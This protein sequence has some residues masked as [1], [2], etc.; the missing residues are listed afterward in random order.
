MLYDGSTMDEDYQYRCSDVGGVLPSLHRDKNKT[1]DLPGDFSLLVDSSHS[2]LWREVGIAKSIRS[3]SSEFDQSGNLF[4]RNPGGWQLRAHLLQEPHMDWPTI[5]AA[6]VTA[7][8]ASSPAV[9]ALILGGRL[10]HADTAT[11]YQDLADKTIAKYDALLEL[12]DTLR[13]G[14]GMLQD[15]VDKL[16]DENTKKEKFITKLLEYIDY[17][18]EL[19]NKNGIVPERPRP[20]REETL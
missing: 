10:R 12:V 6:G 5:I 11:R 18:T 9:A 13:K 20:T 15:K 1:V 14:L 8:I 2:V 16:E 19:M 4:K 7:L 3:R 17:L